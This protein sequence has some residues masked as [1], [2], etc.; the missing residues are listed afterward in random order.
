MWDQSF[1][2][3]F[4]R[5][6]KRNLLTFLCATFVAVFSYTTIVA[7]AA[8]AVS[9]VVWN[10]NVT[11]PSLIYN[12]HEFTQ[13]TGELNGPDVNAFVPAN[14]YIY[15]RPALLSPA[16]NSVTV[17]ASTSTVE[18]ISFGAA[19]PTTA[20]SAKYGIYTFKQ[21]STYTL[22]ST[23]TPL[24]V[25]A[26]KAATNESTCTIPGG[27][28]WFICPFTTTM[29]GFMDY[30]YGVLTHFLTVQPLSLRQNS[31][32][33][34]AW[35]FMRNIAN[36]AFVIAFLVIIYSQLT[37]IGLS[38]YGIK[39]VL[40]RI[41]L[42]AILVNISYFICAIAV[43]ISNVTG[44]SINKLFEMI[45][46]GVV[47][48]GTANVQ[49]TTWTALSGLIIGGTGAAA[50]GGGIYSTLITGGA[51]GSIG[52]AAISVLLPLLVI[53]LLGV[54]VALLVMAAR[55]AII[56]ILVIIS[57]LAF[58]AYLLPNTEKYLDKW[59][60]AFTTLLAL[61]PIVGFVFGGSQLAGQIIIQ[62][63]TSI[64]V[65]LFGMAVQTA[66]LVLTPL[67]VKFSGGLVGRV[68]GMVN[69]PNKGII[70]RTRNFA[71][72]KAKQLAMKRQVS[73][74]NPDGTPKKY[75]GFRRLQGGL[76][77]FARNSDLR[78]RDRER[79][80]KEN[81][82][83]FDNFQEAALD[84]KSRTKVGDIERT[85]KLKVAIDE[86]ALAKAKLEAMQ[87]EFKAGV[88]TGAKTRSGMTPA[89][90]DG[91]VHQSHQTS[92]ELEM[93]ESRK[94]FAH[95]RHESDLLK[96][97]LANT[98]IIDGRQLRNYGA[99]IMGEEGANTL[100]AAATAASR[101]E[102][103]KRIGEGA[104]L[105]KHFELSSDERYNVAFGTAVTKTKNGATY[106][107]RPD[108][109]AVR[110]AAIVDV[111]KTGSEGQ[112]LELVAQS[113]VGGAVHAYATTVSGELPS[114]G[115][116]ILAGKVIDDVYRGKLPTGDAGLIEAA[117]FQITNGKLTKEKLSTQGPAT[118]K[119][120]INSWNH[121][122]TL[123][124][125]EQ[126]KFEANY[127][128]MIENFQEV[129]TSDQLSGA[130]SASSKIEIEKAIK[131]FNKKTP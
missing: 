3:P 64:D 105:M 52:S 72:E 88:Y 54:F 75:K 67:L 58:V 2:L 5:L 96:E 18:I 109:D 10:T 86:A 43:D 95:K 130:V 93:T 42:V 69:N 73:N 36:V 30:L 122:T 82:A 41:I 102:F 9:Q 90:V 61:F 65:V 63:A 123:N 33:Y 77:T 29:A 128:T 45:R 114:L 112:K 113:G 107:F 6:T 91:L 71:D 120:L 124:P 101:S 47:D 22:I 1:V 104:E 80:F 119:H 57:P 83:I 8:A 108:N 15:A 66:P 21:P 48:L 100:L 126:A 35:S 125:E 76:R 129:I 31:P 49:L 19:D 25:T 39:R 87:E 23:L 117:Q 59:Q 81:T 12:S 79:K 27:L 14:T 13:A 78:R 84:T 60:D 28:G 46:N 34:K 20:T 106:T 70:D 55:Q 98:A 11:P 51:M 116:V 118:L 92:R 37:S 24:T 74:L 62:S 121:R 115:N 50:A 40:P 97:K 94:Q 7:P 111:F 85:L 16:E 89:F 56:T 4:G 38:N 17:P 26:Q 53:V 110:E 68:A 103:G 127:R 32:L 44:D 99:G 131:N